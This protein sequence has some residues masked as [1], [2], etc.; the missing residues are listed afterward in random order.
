MDTY[1]I[2]HGR[3][4]QFDGRIIHDGF[5]NT[6]SFIQGSKKI[7]LSL[8]QPSKILKSKTRKPPCQNDVLLTLKA[9]DICNQLTKAIVWRNSDCERLLGLED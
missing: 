5:K 7:T 1:H 6:Y 2:L 9:L 8:L 4:W 3:P